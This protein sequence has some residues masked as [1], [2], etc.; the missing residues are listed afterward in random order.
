MLANLLL[1]STLS[2]PDCTMITVG[3]L[4]LLIGFGTHNFSGRL[5]LYIS[6][7]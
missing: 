7:A 2:A 6:L 5:S 1:S 3:V 4:T